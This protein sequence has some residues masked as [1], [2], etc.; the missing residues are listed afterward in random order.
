MHLVTKSADGKNLNYYGETEAGDSKTG[1]TFS[2]TGQLD[3]TPSGDP[4]GTEFQP[5]SPITK[6]RDGTATY[7]EGKDD[8]NMWD[9]ARHVLGYDKLDTLAKK[10]EAANLIKL[11]EK[12]PQ[13]AKRI[14]EGQTIHLPA[15]SFSTLPDAPDKPAADQPAVVAPAPAKLPAEAPLPTQTQ[16]DDPVSD[17]TIEDLTRKKNTPGET[18]VDGTADALATKVKKDNADMTAAGNAVFTDK[19]AQILGFSDKSQIAF[20]STNVLDDFADEAR[21]YAKKNPNDADAQN[22]V[23]GLQYMKDNWSKFE[24]TGMSG[25]PYLDAASFKRLMDKRTTNL[26]ELERLSK[27]DPS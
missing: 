8:H 10:N 19:A 25:S 7:T 4:R 6:L 14:K 1:K 24:V 17:Q 15:M 20:S 2:R 9:V 5:K 13:N 26:A 11:L 18:P 12:D 21:A 27:K 22:L 16:L 23:K 3:N